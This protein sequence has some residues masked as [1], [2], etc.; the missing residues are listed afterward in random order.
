MTG[1]LNG[2]SATMSI[3]VCRRPFTSR[4]A[5]ASHHGL[6]HG[7]AAAAAAR[8]DGDGGPGPELL[9]VENCCVDDEICIAADGGT[10][11]DSGGGS[12]EFQSTAA[13]AAAAKCGHVRSAQNLA[14]VVVASLSQS[15]KSS[16][17]GASSVTTPGLA[18]SSSSSSSSSSGG[19]NNNNSQTK[20]KNVLVTP[21]AAAVR[22]TPGPAS[23]VRSLAM[24]AAAT[25]TSVV[26]MSGG[27][28]SGLVMARKPQLTT[29]AATALVSRTSGQAEE[30]IFVIFAFSALTLLVGRQEGH[31]ACKKTERW[32]AGAGCYRSISPV[33]RALSSL[34][35]YKQISSSPRFVMSI[36]SCCAP[37]WKPKPTTAGIISAFCQIIM[38]C[39]RNAHILEIFY[40]SPFEVISKI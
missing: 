16:S 18:V 6:V 4:A 34:R 23:I 36:C 20:N 28:L 9:L 8:L 7:P 13:A 24:A 26:Q 21:G 31:P 40:L 33:Y 2:V 15:A 38:N 22:S 5:L 30:V 11:A 35:I 12:A 1:A 27:A 25:S 3:Q 39:S 32:G 19:G 17:A 14:E 10:A 37:V 29:T